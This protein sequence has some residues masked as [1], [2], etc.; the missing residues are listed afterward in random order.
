MSRTL[1]WILGIVGALIVLAIIAS[2]VWAWQNRAQLTA[3]NR[4][5][6]AQPGIPNQQPY[7][8]GQRGFGDDGRGPMHGWAFRGPMMMGRGGRFGGMFG[9]GMFFLGGLFRLFLLL[10]VLAIVAFLFY[11]LGRNSSRTVVRQVTSTSPTPPN[12]PNNE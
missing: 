1:K 6:A 5:Y 3:G 7:Q 11:Q 2:G 4:P 9:M 12:P 10:A 8:S